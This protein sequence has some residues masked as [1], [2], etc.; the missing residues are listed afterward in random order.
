MTAPINGDDAAPHRALEHSVASAKL[1]VRAHSGILSGMIAEASQQQVVQQG[2]GTEKLLASFG[3]EKLPAGGVSVHDEEDVILYNNRSSSDDFSPIISRPGGLLSSEADAGDRDGRS[4]TSPDI[5]KTITQF[6]SSDCENGEQTVSGGVQGGLGPQANTH[7]A[8]VGHYEAMTRC[9]VDYTRVLELYGQRVRANIE[10]SVQKANCTLCAS[11]DKPLVKR[12]EEPMPVEVLGAAVKGRNPGPYLPIPKTTGGSSKRKVVGSASALP[13]MKRLKS[14]VGDSMPGADLLLE[15]SHN[16]FHGGFQQQHQKNSLHG[17]SA[18]AETLQNPS[19]IFSQMQMSP[20]QPVE[21]R[22]V[23][24]Q[25]NLYGEAMAAAD[26]VDDGFLPILTKAYAGPLVDGH[27]SDVGG[28][29]DMLEHV[30]TRGD[31]LSRLIPEAGHYRSRDSAAVAAVDCGVD[32]VFQGAYSAFLGSSVDDSCNYPMNLGDAKGIDVSGR[33]T[34]DSRMATGHEAAKGGD[35][36]FMH[37]PTIARVPSPWCLY[38]GNDD[39]IAREHHHP[40]FFTQPKN[41]FAD[42]SAVAPIF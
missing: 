17:I 18:C 35:A 28:A 33:R 16:L 8:S 26:G 41:E 37:G 9:I 29:S 24:Q 27:S 15:G 20:P 1:L 4:S 34:P 39:R 3:D 19:F 5:L 23:F 11:F 7:V 36:L 31:Y 22:L 30:G 21:G 14:R 42:V 40:A 2:A 13:K 12:R 38:S 25:S 6:S 32:P 10:S